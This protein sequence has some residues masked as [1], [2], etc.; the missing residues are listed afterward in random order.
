MKVTLL[1]PAMLCVAVLAQ[2]AFA[3]TPQPER[4]AVISQH[5]FGQ[6]APQFECI[7]HH[8]STDGANLYNYPNLGPWQIDVQAHAWVNVKR[9]VSDWWY[10]ARIA[11]SISD[12][13]QDFSPWAADYSYCSN[14]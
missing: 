3:G 13:G 4:L 9:V 5:V 8:E 2:P 14:L 6:Y 7:A 10:S 11:W 1:I 12:H